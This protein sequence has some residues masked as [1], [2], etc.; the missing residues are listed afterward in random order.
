MKKKTKQHT[1]YL[2]DKEKA[3]GIYNLSKNCSDDCIIDSVIERFPEY[4]E[5]S[6]LDRLQSPYAKLRVFVAIQTLQENVKRFFSSVIAPDAALFKAGL[7]SSATMMFISMNTNLFVVTTGIAYTCVSDIIDS[8]FG[9]EFVSKFADSVGINEVTHRNLTGAVY[10]NKRNFV[11]EESLVVIDNLNAINKGVLVRIRDVNFLL[12][13]LG[14]NSKNKKKSVKVSASAG[15]KICKSLTIDDLLR[16]LNFCNSLV[17]KGG[18]N[19]FSSISVVTP[20]HDKLL[21]KSLFKQLVDDIFKPQ[22]S[23]KSLFLFH[24]SIDKFM[25]AV[26][27]SVLYKGGIFYDEEDADG[28]IDAIRAEYTRRCAHGK[29][30]DRVDFCK[31]ITINSKNAD[32]ISITSD[33]LLNHVVCE[34]YHEGEMY[35]FDHGNIYK[36][37]ASYMQRL[38]RELR[39][40]VEGNVRVSKS[41]GVEWSNKEDDYN[42]DLTR[43]LKGIQLHKITPDNIEFADVLDVKEDGLQIIHVKDGFDGS[44]RVLTHQVMLS[45][46]CLKDLKHDSTYMRKVYEQATRTRRE[47]LDYFPTFD[48][49]AEVLRTRDITYV[50]VLRVGEK[51][52]DFES[53][54]QCKSTIAKHCLLQIVDEC[55]LN[56]VKLEVE[57]V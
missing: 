50:I 10:Q 49:F 56:H 3:A 23:V 42:M 36:V 57:L 6:V 54:L 17:L 47:M 9:M 25:Q 31:C 30:I 13:Y 44:M 27:Y 19:L 28:I 39:R 52:T 45:L 21:R 1:I 4:D 40:K 8:E 7:Q 43:K 12:E 34:L 48:S 26:S 11:K 41:F 22:S 32:G 55:Y 24:S 53:L 2:I 14:V 29:E 15:L 18:E 16:L 20:N 35:Y 51:V 5:E 33:S 37:S 46:R 38:T